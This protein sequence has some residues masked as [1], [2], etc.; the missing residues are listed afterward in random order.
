V[1]VVL[2]GDKEEFNMEGWP[3]AEEGRVPRRRMVFFLCYCPASFPLPKYEQGKKTK[4][5][6]E[7]Q[8]RSQWGKQR[9]CPST[10]LWTALYI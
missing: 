6:L 3:F 9:L 8:C 4:L 2:G 5:S 1:R 7:T 10:S